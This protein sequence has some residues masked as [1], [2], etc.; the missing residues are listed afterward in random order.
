MT[1]QKGRI[2]IK[3]YIEAQFGY[4]PLVWMFCG[5]SLNNRINRIYEKSLRVVYNDYGSNFI[6]LLERDGSV[7]I[8]HRNIQSLAIKIFKVI[9]GLSPEIMKEVFILKKN[10]RYSTTQMFETSSR[11]VK[12]TFLGELFKL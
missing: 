12:D 10:V 8:H 1:V 7:T 2:I 3:S 6:Q 9:K 11:A 4:C 5:K